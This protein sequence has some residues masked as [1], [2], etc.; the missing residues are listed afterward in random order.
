[1]GLPQTAV[2]PDDLL[3]IAVLEQ[4]SSRCVGW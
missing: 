3:G 1:V 2:G 4:P